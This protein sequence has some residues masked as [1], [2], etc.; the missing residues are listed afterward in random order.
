MRFDITVL[1]FVALMA[2]SVLAKSWDVTFA[3]GKFSPQELD[4]APGDTVVWPNNDGAD[5]AIVETDA[6]ARSCVSKVG[7]FNSGLKTKGQAYQ[8]TFPAAA[9]VNYK[10]GIGANCVNGATGTI[11]VGPRPANDPNTG[12]TTTTNGGVATPTMTASPIVTPS[13]TSSPTSSPTNKPN[14]AY[15]LS[16][17]GNALFLGAVCFVGAIAGL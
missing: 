14:S 8:R 5:H 3:N 9:V 12:N 4:I 2:P 15:G 11:F 13:P 6:G 16:A 17:S 1:A 10:D 7:G